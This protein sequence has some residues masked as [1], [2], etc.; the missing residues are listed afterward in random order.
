MRVKTLRRAGLAAAVVAGAMAV[1]TGAASAA[2][3]TVTN[4]DDTG[5]GSLRQAITAANAASGAD[6]V[7]FNIPGAGSHTIAV[8]S[9]PLP[10]VTGRLKIDGAT[11]PG[12]AGI[13]LIRIDNNT[14]AT[15]TNGIDISA[16]NSQVLS[17][18][19]TGFGG[20]VSLR[21]NGA[22][23]VSGNRLGL[24]PAGAVDGNVVGVGIVGGSTGNT[25]GGTTAAARNVLSGNG[26]GVFIDASNAN[27][28]QGNFVGVSPTGAAAMPNTAA[29]IRVTGGAKNT[30]VGGTVAGSGN[31][32]SANVGGGININ[33]AGTSGTVVAGNKIGTNLAGTA[34]LP[35]SQFGVGILGAATAN[36]VGGTTAAARNIISGNENGSGVGISGDGTDGNVVAGNFIGTNATGTAALKNARGVLLSNGAGANTVGGDRA[37]A[38]NLISGN[39]GD[40]VDVQGPGTDDNVIAGNDIG[41]N[42]AGNAALP[43]IGGVVIQGGKRTL[44]G[45]ASAARRNVISGNLIRGVFIGFTTSDNAVKANFV[46]T[47]PAG[48]AALPNGGDGVRIQD[49]ASTGNTVGGT[50]AG[51]RNVISGNGGQGVMI[52]GSSGNAVTG[53]YIGLALNGADPLGNAGRGVDIGLNANANRIGGLTSGQ[54]NVIAANNGGGVRIAGSENNVLQGN[55][56][57]TAANGSAPIANAGPGVEVRIASNDNTIGGTQS[58]AGNLIAFNGGPGVRVDSADGASDGN[59]ILRNSIGD[60]ALLGIQLLGG[61]NGAQAA[62][63]VTTVTS[64]ATETTIKGTLA[65]GPAKSAFRIEA[66]VS[67]VCDGTGFG[68]GKRFLAAKAITTN[69]AGDG[70]FSIKVGPLAAGQFVTATATRGT[71][72]QNTSEFSQCRPT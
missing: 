49:A 61:A 24:T 70:T 69:A 31:V 36:T 7:R 48:N 10:V 60:N 32:I 37:T 64:T 14:G 51:E 38:R 46:G 22:N 47:T 21:T 33:G 43:N 26:E 34:A 8:T 71:G 72:P 29:G 67:P 19:V 62:P 23:M 20:G 17:L 65:G 50:S 1:T 4:T 63:D 3:F 5:A 59:A 55:Y 16:G 18:S 13:P 9:A 41:L 44:V 52:D 66:F 45:G 15:F 30:V 42:L 58:G 57:G 11:E 39:D 6:E 25:I 28:I 27:K 35:N 54:R 2:I 40:G 68:E 53:N 56:I 12:F